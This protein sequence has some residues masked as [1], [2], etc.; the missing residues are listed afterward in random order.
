VYA[1]QV[2]ASEDA[3]QQAQVKYAVFAPKP[4]GVD[5]L[6]ETGGGDMETKD[7]FAQNAARAA[8]AN[9]TNVTKAKD[10]LKNARHGELQAIVQRMKRRVAE[11]NQQLASIQLRSR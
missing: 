3:E 9:D 10:S 7:P 4:E 1:D 8:E 2:A 5:F 6:A 11:T